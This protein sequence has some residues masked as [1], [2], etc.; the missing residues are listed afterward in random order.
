MEELEDDFEVL[1]LKAIELWLP[2]V[3]DRRGRPSSVHEQRDERSGGLPPWVDGG[4]VAGGGEGP[5]GRR[6]PFFS[7]E[8]TSC[9]GNLA[10]LQDWG[11]LWPFG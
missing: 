11:G 8:Q 5:G 7:R 4:E 9:T 2:D 3:Q 6:R 1:T 10:L